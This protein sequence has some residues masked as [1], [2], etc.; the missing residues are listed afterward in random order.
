MFSIQTISE[1][2]SFLLD[3][4]AAKIGCLLCVFIDYDYDYYGY[5][6]YRGGYSDPYY[7]DYYR[8]EDYYFDYP[9]PPPPARGRGRQPQPVGRSFQVVLLTFNRTFGCL[10]VARRSVAQL[11]QVNDP[12]HFQSPILHREI[13]T[14]RV[15][16]MQRTG[17]NANLMDVHLE[18]AFVHVTVIQF[19]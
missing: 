15:M 9:P 4:V 2:D 3:F 10:I 8:Y 1:T 7:D 6:D 16:A 19:R 18:K 14:N 5:G 12:S 11:D 13:P 17:K